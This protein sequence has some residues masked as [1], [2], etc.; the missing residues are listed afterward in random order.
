MSSI[1]SNRQRYSPKYT[2]ICIGNI[3]NH[4][5]PSSLLKY[6]E[7]YGSIIQYNFTSPTGGYVFIT[8]KEPSMV[9]ACMKSRPHHLD[10]RHLYVKRALPIDD[11]HPRERFE[12]TRDLMIIIDFDNKNYNDKEFLTQLREYFSSYGTLYACKYCHETYFNY[13]LVEFA[14]KDQVDR[15]ILDKPHY[16]NEHQLNVM[17]CIPSNIEIMNKKYSLNKQQSS[18]IIKDAIDDDSYD[19]IKSRNNFN[20]NDSIA[21]EHISEIDLEN[22]VYRLQNILKT[23]NEDFATKRQQLE[24]QCSEQLKKLDAD[25]NQ[26]NRLQ[27]DLEQEYA[28][29]LVEYESMKHE[30]ESLNEQYLAAE[31]ENFEITSYYEQILSEE[32]AK[33]IQLE[34]QYTQK[35]KTL[36][37][38]HSSSPSS[39]RLISNTSSKSS[40]QS[41]VPKDN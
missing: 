13:I 28:K 22:E 26:T 37:S 40:S 32:K 36:H 5:E 7:Q 9:D 25:T 16:Y 31:L 11:E 3:N 6:F 19:Y 30:N 2:E 35:L 38:N 18:M 17:K 23:M 1:S 14:D 33:T 41:I 27:Q 34:N 39:P 12:T 29:L 24:D 4:T 21:K 8:Y 15:I 10:G 20:K